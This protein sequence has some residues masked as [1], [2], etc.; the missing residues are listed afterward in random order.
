MLAGCT[1]Q[2]LPSYQ[3]AVSAIL[4]MF[5]MIRSVSRS[6]SNHRKAVAPTP[7]VKPASNRGLSETRLSTASV[8]PYA[9]RPAKPQSVTMTDAVIPRFHRSTKRTN[10]LLLSMGSSLRISDYCAATVP[11]SIPDLSNAFTGQAALLVNAS[12]RHAPAGLGQ[13][14][15]G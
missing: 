6:P 4:L 5:P 13:L 3:S 9:N 11:P 1:R 2:S 15:M 10:P 7:N 8:T 14:R 12:R